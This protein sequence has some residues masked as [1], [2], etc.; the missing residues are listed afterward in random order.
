MLFCIFFRIN[1]KIT[2]SGD[3]LGAVT[4]VVAHLT[5]VVA[6]HTSSTRAVACNMAPAVAPENIFNKNSCLN[7]VLWCMH[8]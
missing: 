1:L 4:S 8:T 3:H 5:T 7:I 6:F 2:I